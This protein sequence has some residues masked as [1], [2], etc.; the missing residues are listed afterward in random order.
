MDLNTIFPE[1]FIITS[2][3]SYTDEQSIC[4]YLKSNS[5]SV[6]YSICQIETSDQHIYYEKNLRIHLLSVNRFN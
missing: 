1:D 2:I 4:I 3:D 6:S 5:T